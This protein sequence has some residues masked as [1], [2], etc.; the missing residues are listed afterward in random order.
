M[1]VGAQ[2][3]KIMPALPAAKRQLYLPHL[4]AAMRASGIGTTM[5]HTAAFVAQLAH[6]SGEFRWMEESWGRDGGAASLRAAKRPRAAP[7]QYG[8]RERRPC[9]LTASLPTHSRVASL[10]AVT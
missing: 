4:N 9:S 7:G 5:Q 3:Q 10:L 2:M 8:T 6:E 1:L